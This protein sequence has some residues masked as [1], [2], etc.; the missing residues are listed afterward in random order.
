MITLDVQE[1]ILDIAAPYEAILLDAYGVFWGGNEVGLFPGVL[2]T[3]Q[4]LI[5]LGKKIGVLSNSTQLGEGMMAKLATKGLRKGEHFHF[6]IS[7]GDV[8]KQ[9]FTSDAL[10]FPTPKKSYILFNPPHAKY[11]SPHAL[12]EGSPFTESEDPDFIYISIP[13][14]DNADQ[15][16]PELF[17]EQVKTFARQNL[18]VVCANPD[19][20][21]HEG[22]PPEPVVRQ[23]TIAKMFEEHGAN[24]V[25][26]GKPASICYEA[27]MR[28]FK[29][30]GITEPSNVLMVG[31]TPETDIRG[32][33]RAGMDSALVLDTGIMQHR[34]CDNLPLED[35]PT[36]KIKRLASV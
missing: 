23:G 18:P 20:T 4:K 29:E 11:S 7:S 24:V 10:S 14:I 26:I 9:I 34:T 8:A 35:R 17:R 33:N 13:H 36:Y 30:L 31:D 3:L 27:A 2:E 16:D 12:F 25:Y 6:L 22:M 1:H 19:L 5:S 15:K 21:A 28:Q 32:A